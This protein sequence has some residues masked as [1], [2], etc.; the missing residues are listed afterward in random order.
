MVAQIATNTEFAAA[1]ARRSW[2]DRVL[3]RQPEGFD[4]PFASARIRAA[5]HLERTSL[6]LHNSLR[7]A[8]ALGLA[9]LVADLSS[10]Q[11][12]FWVAFGTL[13]V[14]RSNALS[15]GQSVLRALAGTAVGFVVGGA[16]VYLI[17]TNTAVLWVLL[18]FADPARRPRAG[19]DLLRRGAGRVHGHAADPVQHHRPRRLEDRAGASRGRG[20]R[21]RGQPGGRPAVLAPRRGGRAR[22][23]AGRRVCRQRP[24]PRRRGGLR[25]RAL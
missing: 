22:S 14:L 12:G 8:V 9:V 3:G 6:W 25:S 13:S 20:A 18:P 17:G 21:G 11:H 23:R 16:L 24:L 15:T 5:A 4:G 19:D 10:V 7:G 2:R 1:A